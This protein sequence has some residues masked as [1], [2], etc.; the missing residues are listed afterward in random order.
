L[1][2]LLPGQRVRSA[3]SLGVSDDA[4]EAICFAVF[5]NNLLHGE[6]NNLPSATGAARQT[7][8]GKLALPE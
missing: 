4:K 3:A 1:G 7:V 2:D 5:G 6:P 8:M